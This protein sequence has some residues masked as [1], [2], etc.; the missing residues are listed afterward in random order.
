MPY[1]MPETDTVFIHI[2]KTAGSSV[3]SWIRN[4]LEFKYTDRPH[5][6]YR[7]W[8]KKHG[9]PSCHF[10]TVRNPYIRIFS[11]F[12]FQ[13]RLITD[14][15]EQGEK[16]TSTERGNLEVYEKGFAHWIAMDDRPW[17]YKD[18]KRQQVQYFD[19]N[20]ALK[21]HVENFDNDFVKIQEHFNCFEPIGF[22]NVSK[23]SQLDYREHYDKK[24]KA[25]VDKI[26]ADDLA[27]LGYSF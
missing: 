27:Y 11:W 22:H 26:Y 21:V 18:I 23:S 9:V 8:V 4:N 25:F 5:D 20:T 2:P 3:T 16:L 1:Y 15:I 19:R 24:S 12:H 14:K 7:H 13:G 10:V 6:F 17:F